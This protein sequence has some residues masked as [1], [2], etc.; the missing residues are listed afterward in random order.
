MDQIINVFRKVTDNGSVAEESPNYVLKCEQSSD[1]RDVPKTFTTDG[2][3]MTILTSSGKV[4][5]H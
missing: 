3:N 2:N 1:L 4:N 5:D